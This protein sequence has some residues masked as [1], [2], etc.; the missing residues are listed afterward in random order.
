MNVK[1]VLYERV[2]ELALS[3]VLAKIVRLR[4]YVPLLMIGSLTFL[5]IV[6]KV[7]LWGR[8][9]NFVILICNCRAV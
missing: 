6:Y 3:Q 8:V 5:I 7:F 4:I 1:A 2:Y 9:N